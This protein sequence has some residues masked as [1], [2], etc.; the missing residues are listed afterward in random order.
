MAGRGGLPGETRNYLMRV[1][2]QPAEQWADAEALKN[3]EMS[4]MPPRAPCAEV[5]VAVRQQARV[6]RVARLVMD[7]A[8]ATR[9]VEPAVVAARPAPSD[10]KQAKG[11]DAKGAAGRADKRGRGRKSA[12]ASDK[13]VKDAR[14]ADRRE[15]ERNEK[16]AATDGRGSKDDVSRDSR[17]RKL[18]E[19]ATTNGKRAK[20]HATR[21]PIEDNVAAK[22]AK[23]PKDRK[24][25]SAREQDSGRDPVRSKAKP[26]SRRSA[27]AIASP[28]SW[29]AARR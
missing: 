17:K 7:L 5:V 21:E 29:R 10:A 11:K 26:V 15:E 8:A 16:I 18:A 22:A 14:H 24:S 3:P 25:K 13:P 27:D 28:R 20:D 9:P 12:K 2:G 1:T 19:K 6:V 4:L 23:T